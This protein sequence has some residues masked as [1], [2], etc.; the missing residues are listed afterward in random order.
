MGEGPGFAGPPQWYGAPNAIHSTIPASRAILPHTFVK[1]SLRG[2]F[3]A[4]YSL[5]SCH[6]AADIHQSQPSAT[7]I[8]HFFMPGAQ[9]SSVDMVFVQNALKSCAK[10]NENLLHIFRTFITKLLPCY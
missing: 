1:V 10:S 3:C 7:L 9:H 4:I 5:K 6:L 2:P 8:Q